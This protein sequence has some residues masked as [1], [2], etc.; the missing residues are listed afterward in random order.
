[1][2]IMHLHQ[3]FHNPSK[4]YSANLEGVID[5]E[6]ESHLETWEMSH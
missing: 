2:K 3:V 5:E 6:G 1:M 4:K